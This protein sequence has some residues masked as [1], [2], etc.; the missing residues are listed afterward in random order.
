MLELYSKHFQIRVLVVIIRMCS[1]GKEKTGLE[2]HKT[3]RCYNQETVQVWCILQ[4]QIL[5][6]LHFKLSDWGADLIHLCCPDVC[7]TNSFPSGAENAPASAITSTVAPVT[8][9]KLLLVPS[10]SNLNNP[11]RFAF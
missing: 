7:A 5:K 3:Y 9:A 2:I 1:L 8:G 10:C 4:I 6:R 11:Y